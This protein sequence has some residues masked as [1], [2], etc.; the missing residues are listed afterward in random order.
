M[1]RTKLTAAAVGTVAA[2]ALAGCAG[3]AAGTG[4][5]G[6]V[7]LSLRLWD[8]KVADAYEPS[9][10][11]FEA[12]NPGITVE[13]NV[14]PWSDY[15]TTLRADVAAGS[16]DDVFWLNGSY[17]QDYVDND[18]L[19]GITETLGADATNAWNPQVIEQ[20]TKNGELW[21]VP[22][23]TDG[24]SALYY[25][26]E[27]LAKAGVTPADLQQLAWHPTD[28]AADTFLPLLQR[29]TLDSSGRSAADPAFDANAVE[30]WG[31]NA[32]Q[33]L[34]NIEL[35]FIGSNGGTYQDAEGKLTFTDPKTVEAYAYLVRLINEHRVAPPASS[36][37][38]DGDYTRDQFLQGKIALFESGTY[39][40]ANVHDGAT[41]EWGIVQIP[42][43]PAGRVTTAPGVI[44]AGNAAT[45]HPAETAALL[46]WL[47][48]TEGNEF[49][50]AQG[51]AVPA[52]TEARAAYDAYWQGVGV[53][54]SPFFTV[55]EG[56][57]QIDPVTGQNFGAMYAAFKPQLDEVFLGRTDVA[58]GLQQA[59]DAGNGAA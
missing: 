1:N 36:T 5:G 43:G 40:L 34:Q 24:G 53:D 49:I 22:Q 42:S 32:A 3:G 52:V 12:A 50:G 41:F 4:A 28:A 16:G 38:S 9:I 56:N 8:E 51:A 46:R 59:Q 47:G 17:Y 14:V 57:A 25:N 13:L 48:S 23:L 7:T 35:N 55:L 54:V 6:D 45:A 31:F 27:A 58:T 30:Q 21:G 11:A 39:N 37:N 29:L 20:Y 44:A 2:L 18:M 15:F 19:L 10:A 33:E 26:A